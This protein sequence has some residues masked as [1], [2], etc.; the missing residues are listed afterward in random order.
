MMIHALSFSVLNFLLGQMKAAYLAP[1]RVT[2]RAR[3]I[4]Y[5][6][7]RGVECTEI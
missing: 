6:P 3:G 7:E 1:Q 5:L 2:R 4:E